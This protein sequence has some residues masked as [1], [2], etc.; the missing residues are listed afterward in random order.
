MWIQIV[1][2]DWSHF[3]T[4]YIWSVSKFFQ[5]YLQISSFSPP[6]LAQVTIIS[7]LNHCSGPL[8]G[9]PVSS[10]TLFLF[11][12]QPE[13]VTLL[14]YKSDHATLP[15]MFQQL[16]SQSNNKFLTKTYTTC[17]VW[18]PIS[19]LTPLPGSL[20]DSH[21]CSHSNP[22]LCLKPT[23]HFPCQAFAHALLPA[24]NTHPLKAHMTYSLNS[25]GLYSHYLPRD[26]FPAQTLQNINPPNPFL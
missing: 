18:S 7:H 8:S 25:W 24:W 15:K 14:K 11:T 20:P 17:L 16:P 2:F 19:S 6:L 26:T 4:T 5:F 9:L 1:I 13:R 22:L 10:L 21:S 12:Q 23:A 3:L